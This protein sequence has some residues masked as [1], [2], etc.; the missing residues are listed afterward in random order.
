MTLTKKRFISFLVLSLLFISSFSYFQNLALSETQNTRILD[1]VPINRDTARNDMGWGTGNGFN[2]PVFNGTELSGRSINLNDYAGENLLLVFASPGCPYCKK[3]VPLLN[4]IVADGDLKVVMVIS[5]NAEQATEFQQTQNAKFDIIADGDYKISQT[6]GIRSVPQGFLIEQGMITFSTIS[7]GSSIWN[8]LASYEHDLVENVQ[9]APLSE[10]AIDTLADVNILNGAIGAAEGCT[11]DWQCDDYISCTTD[12]CFSGICYHDA[13]PGYC[14]IGGACVTDGTWNGQCEYCDSEKNDSVWWPAVGGCYDGYDCN[15]GDYCWSGSCRPGLTNYCDDGLDCTI[16]RCSSHNGSLYCDYE[17]IAGSCY[18]DNACYAD[19][20]INPDNCQICN[21][22]LDQYEWSIRYSGSCDDG[23]YCTKWDHCSK[24]TCIGTPYTCDDGIECTLN[25]CTGSGGCIYPVDDEHCLINGQCI[26]AGTVCPTMPCKRC[27]PSISKTTWS[28][29][30]SLSCNDGLSCTYNDHCSNG[31]C[32]GTPF[33]CNDGK[34][35]TDDICNGNNT[36]TYPVQNGKCLIN[37]VCYNRGAV[38]P[39]NP[40]QECRDDMG[41]QYKTQWYNDNTNSCSDGS[42]CTHTDHC[43]SGTCVGTSYVCNDGL[44][45][46]TD[47]CN[48]DGTCTY[49]L[50]SGYCQINGGCYSRGTLNPSNP[51]QECR[52]DMGSQYKTQWYNDNTNPGV[53]DWLS[54]TSDTCNNGATVHTIIEGNCLI[55]LNCYSRGTLKPTNPCQECR[56]DMGSQY[57]TQWYNDNTNPGSSDGMGCTIDTC[58]NGTTIHTI[59]EGNC[60]IN[61]NC[62]SRGESHPTQHC[63]I[64]RDDIDPYTWYDLGDID[65]DNACDNYDNCPRM[66]NPQQEDFDENERGDKCDPFGLLNVWGYN[67][68]HQ[69]DS[70]PADGGYVQVE[71][72]YYH[73]TALKDDGTIV[74]WGQDDYGQVSGIPAGT[75]FAAISSKGYHGLAIKNDGSVVGWGRN[76]HGQASPPAR[77]DIIAIATGVFHSIALTEAGS[78]IAWGRDNYGQ[79]NVP[80]GNDFIG[81]SANMNHCIALRSNGS[82]CSWGYDN[83]GQVSD[84]PSGND[85]IDISAGFWYSLALKSDGSIVAWGQGSATT[86]L[87]PSGNNYVAIAAGNSN[88]L[89]LK[90]DGTIAGWGHSGYGET[91][92][93][94]GNTY[95]DISSGYYFSAVI[96][97]CK[98]MYRGDIN[99]DCY[100]DLTDLQNLSLEW[101]ESTE[102]MYAD[103][104]ASSEVNFDDF[105]ILADDWMKCS[106]PLDANCQ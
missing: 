54:C 62:Y 106:H 14:Y 31:T 34:T 74:G 42:N 70:E 87:P 11:G 36:C 88:N 80:A 64:C 13:I 55:G 41:G 28:N 81:I 67:A 76:D 10:A 57:K 2:A 39:L 38:N 75:D 86:N 72:G 45:C 84:T 29:D 65:G 85:F 51:C 96:Y 60:L 58:N 53:N 1:S 73:A 50:N 71:A 102:P 49:T 3:K 104:D 30:D 18:I 99:F 24:G 77:N 93:P 90:G 16:D 21:S 52:D 105:V 69:S 97:N 82:I 61:F 15:S 25:L 33:T 94:A 12:L 40:C 20:D 78:I 63:N 98:M 83:Y 68:S 59:I 66:Y 47:T 6:Y 17:A 5:A 37:G 22:S 35:C 8:E 27:I 19:G 56:D 9:S 100:T 95:T 44:A 46:T 103:I 89:A 91:T 48:G 101:L 23:D 4:S 32:T 79:L 7:D 43:S 26:D 92:P